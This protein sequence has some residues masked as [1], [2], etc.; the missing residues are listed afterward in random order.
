MRFED[1]HQSRM[2]YVT[3]STRCDKV[4]LTNAMETVSAHSFFAQS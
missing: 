3:P 4:P 1:G 2:R